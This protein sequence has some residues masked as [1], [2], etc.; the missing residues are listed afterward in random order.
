MRLPLSKFAFVVTPVMILASALASGQEYYD[1]AAGAAVSHKDYGSGPNSTVTS[2]QQMM[3]GTFSGV[4]VV[5]ADGAPGAV[6]SVRIRGVH[7]LRGDTQPLYV[8]DGV[9]LNS[10]LLD[11]D[12]TFWSDAEDYQTLQNTLDGI[13]PEDIESVT[14]LKDAAATAIYGSRGGNGVIIITTKRGSEGK[15][16]ARWRSNVYFSGIE[17]KMDFLGVSDWASAVAHSVSGYTDWQKNAS[18]TAVSHAHHLSVDGA[19]GKNDWY[20]SAGYIDQRGVLDA[21]RVQNV[22][23][24]AGLNQKFAGNSVFGVRMNVGYRINEMLMAVSPVGSGSAVKSILMASPISDMGKST[25][26]YDETYSDWRNAYDDNSKSYSVAPSAYID[27]KL[28]KGFSLKVNAGVDW[29]SKTRLRWVG[30]DVLR[31]REVSGR[32]GQTSFNTLSYNADAAL[33]YDL[34]SNSGHVV[35]ASLGGAV[36][37]VNWRENIYEGTTFFSEELR[38]TGISLAENVAPYRHTETAQLSVSVYLTAEYTFR[39]RY[40]IGGSAR[41]EKLTRYDEALDFDNIYP[42]AYFVWNV[43]GEPFLENQNVLSALKLRASWGKSGVQ[44]LRPYGYTDGYITGIAPDFTVDGLTNYYT[45]RWNNVSTQCNAGL[46]FGFLD[47]RIS[48]TIDVYNIG[49]DDRM[50]YYYHVP[51]G[52]YDGVYSNSASIRNRGVEVSLSADII[53]HGNFI[54]S[55]RASYSFN[56]NEILDNGCEGDLFGTSAGTFAGKDVIFNVNRNGQSIGSFYGYK[57]QGIVKEQHT[58]LA[59]AFNG[60]RLQEGDIKFIDVNGDGN[61]T[62]EDMTVIGHSLPYSVASFGTTFKWKGLSLDI[63]FDGAFNFDILNVGK[64]YDVWVTGN[65]SNITSDTV[66]KAWPAGNNPRKDA[67]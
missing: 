25:G 19:S 65:Y 43:A 62:P 11:A 37:G 20:M 3:T 33:S 13:N 35:K 48:G 58:L 31:G 36:N 52:S 12:K 40:T 53:R 51:K 21:G 8:L 4:Q 30:S 60:T 57:S 14:V 26:I 41:V 46:D 15:F 27:A 23:A 61:V 55:A 63:L 49:S 39:N 44:S 5:S 66:K 47:G 24:N 2:V 18:R 10:P 38:A 9:I 29:R 22:T 28:G 42:S 32:A 45:M 64:L 17:K 7:S 6:S 67:V 54:W 59:P 16:S 56:R 34:E 1:I 50:Q